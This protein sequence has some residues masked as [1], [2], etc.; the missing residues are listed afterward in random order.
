MRQILLFC[1]IVIVGFWCLRG[2]ASAVDP[3]YGVSMVAA[4]KVMEGQ[5]IVLT[6]SEL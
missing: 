5:P 2:T 6:L 3:L 4:A 1:Y